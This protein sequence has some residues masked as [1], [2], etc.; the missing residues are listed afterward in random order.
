MEKRDNTTMARVIYI[1]ILIS[2]VIGIT[3]IVALIM[4]YV[5]KDG[6][7]DIMMTHYRF[8]IRTFWIGL[9]YTMIGAL[10]IQVTIGF[11]ILLF[12]FIWVVVRCAKG[13]RWLERHEPVADVE[14][15]M[16]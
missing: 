13:L 15:W 10:L 12:T 2:T 1:L 7:D 11:L 4:A 8:Q 14:T 6:A 5:M 3:G 9:L 16:F